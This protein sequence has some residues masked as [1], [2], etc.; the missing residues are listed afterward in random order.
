MQPPPPVE[1]PAGR[2]R[3]PTNITLSNA[4]VPENRPAGTVV[5]TLD[6]ADADAGDTHTF[7][8]ING[9]GSADN[10]AFAIDGDQ[11]KTA[12]VFDF[13]AKSS[14]SIRVR[15]RDERGAAFQKALTISVTDVAE[16]LNHAPT[17]VSLS[18]ALVDEN[19]PAGS[20]VGTLAATDSDVGDPHT[21]ALVAG[22]GDADN[23]AFTLAGDQLST[24][25][26]FDFESR[27][28]LLD[29]GRDDRRGAGRR[30]PRRSPSRSATSTRR[31]RR[32]RSRTRPCRRTSRAARRSATSR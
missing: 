32:S 14:Y 30:S 3:P 20:A 8:L 9:N 27:S 7:A 2:N 25:Q 17:D 1:A 10:A 13:E 4:G 15:A 23:G 16:F 31:R 21:F 22:S 12:A 18:P 28:T 19:R 5:G 24:A 11:L 29:P 26:T 6:A